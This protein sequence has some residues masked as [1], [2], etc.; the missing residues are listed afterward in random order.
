MDYINSNCVIKRGN[1]TTQDFILPNDISYADI[2]K[3]SVVYSQDGVNVLKKD[4]I[5]LDSNKISVV[6]S[7]SDTLGFRTPH[8]FVEVILHFSKGSVLRSHIYRC[9]IEDTTLDREVM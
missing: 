5:K 8:V 9:A 7:E 3:V 6:L 2:D 1:T 4:I